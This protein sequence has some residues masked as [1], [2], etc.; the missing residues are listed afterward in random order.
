MKWPL[1]REIK[2]YKGHDEVVRV[3]DVQTASG[4]F[5]RAIQYLA[6]FPKLNDEPEE[7]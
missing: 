7:E 2:T 5:K 3:A 6:P 4:I 1:G